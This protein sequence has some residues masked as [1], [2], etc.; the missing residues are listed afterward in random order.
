M[1][2]ASPT[3]GKEKNIKRFLKATN[4]F[5]GHKLHRIKLKVNQKYHS[6][7]KHCM[8]IKK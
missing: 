8:S 2:L 1:C 5:A 4:L 3:K 6:Y 7:D